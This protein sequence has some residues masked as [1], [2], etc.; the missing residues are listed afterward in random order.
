VLKAFT[1]RLADLF[2]E[3]KGQGETLLPDAALMRLQVD[4]RRLIGDAEKLPAS[5]KRKASRVP[6]KSS[7]ARQKQLHH[8]AVDLFY[9]TYFPDGTGRGRPRLPDED[10]QEVKRLKD[11]GESWTKIPAKLGDPDGAKAKDKYRKRARR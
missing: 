2:T 5:T 4:I 3:A 7:V 11:A 9:K 8:L 1:S 10:R 6:L